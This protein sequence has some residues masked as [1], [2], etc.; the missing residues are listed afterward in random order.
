VAGNSPHAAGDGHHFIGI[1][2]VVNIIEQ[3]FQHGDTQNRARAGM[4]DLLK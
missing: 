2:D 4:S 3:R 1:G